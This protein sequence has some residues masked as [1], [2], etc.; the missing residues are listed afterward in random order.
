MK[1]LIGLTAATLLVF[2]PVPALADQWASPQ[3]QPGS[4]GLTLTDSSMDGGVSSL[5]YHDSANQDQYLCSEIGKAPCD[6]AEMPLH[7]SLVLP[8][9]E[10]PEQQN[11]V[12]DLDIRVGTTIYPGSFSNYAPGPTFP[13]NSS[14]GLPKGQTLSRWKVAGLNHSGGN[15][16]YAVVVSLRT[17]SLSRGKVLFDSANL[18][19][20]PF[21]TISGNFQTVQVTQE[22]FSD[23]QKFVSSRGF[24]PQCVWTS[25]GECG[26]K[27]DFAEGSVVKLSVRLTSQIGGWFNGRMKSPDI[28]VTKHLTGSNRIVISGEPATVSRLGFN[29]PRSQATEDLEEYF[30]DARPD[31]TG[32]SMPANQGGSFGMVEAARDQLSD[33]ASGETSTWAIQT[34]MGAR[35]RCMSDTSKVMG[36]VTTNA[37]AYQSEAPTFSQGT[38]KYEVSGLHL[39]PGGLDPV[40]GTYDL[41]M[42]SEVARCLYGF[43]KA[44]LSASITVSGEGDKTI[45]TTTVREK[46]GWLKLAAYGFTFS[47]KTI[48]VKLTQK[49]TTITCVTTKKPTKTKKVTALSPKCPKGY[50]KK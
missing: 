29:V 44:P 28:Q 5:S 11:C 33:T 26:R 35:N 7:G 6:K 39:Q 42:R 9:C 25:S 45:A 15:D 46:S 10:S 21:K 30:Q 41:V 12:E 43:S 49:K 2:T 14:I 37:M 16:D 22:Q 1:K 38:L 31:V 18:Q 34:T 23:G 47:E 8:V 27:Q 50:K 48:K 32:R 4:I 3:P 36:I 40:L 13:A 20:V 17:A 19:V 24:E